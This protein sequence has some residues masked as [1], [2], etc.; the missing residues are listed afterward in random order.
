MKI[1]NYI[2]EY[3]VNGADSLEYI[4]D[5]D[6]CLADFEASGEDNMQDWLE[7]LIN[8]ITVIDEVNHRYDCMADAYNLIFKVNSTYYS[9]YIEYVNEYGTNEVYYDSLQQVVPKQKTITVYESI[10]K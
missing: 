6:G 5:L 2:L 10:D 8:D 9:V 4:D 3:L 7:S 1:K